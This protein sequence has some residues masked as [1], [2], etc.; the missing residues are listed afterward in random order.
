MSNPMIHP[1]VS[2][3]LRAKVAEKTVAT[4]DRLRQAAADFQPIGF[5]SSMGAEDMLLTDLIQRHDIEI[6]IFT[7]D[8]GRLP[9]E[10]YDLMAKAD[11]HYGARPVTWFPR[12]EAVEEYV[13]KHGINAFYH[14]VELRKACC[15]MRKVEPLKRALAGKKAWI[16]G[17]RAQQSTT[18]ADLPLREFDESHG[19]EKFNPLSDWTER[20]VWVYIQTEGVPYNA[21]HEQFFPSIG[22]QPCTRAIS[23]GED[24]RAGRWWWENPES[25]ECGLHVKGD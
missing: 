14:S 9:A 17:M 18:R 20:E 5:A 10:T 19:I 24:I 4:I 13:R 21:L 7:L 2:D 23:P 15:G 3:A 25:K 6:E 1:N 22:C 8:T 12:H 16:T 11:S